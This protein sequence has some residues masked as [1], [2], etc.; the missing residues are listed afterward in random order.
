MD[1]PR[2]TVNK[3]VNLEGVEREQ[4]T[5]GCL[6]LSGKYEVFYI[7]DLSGE[8]SKKHIVFHLLHSA[9]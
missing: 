5:F 9:N 7:M 2:I 1:Y 6:A 8:E 3:L 4:Q